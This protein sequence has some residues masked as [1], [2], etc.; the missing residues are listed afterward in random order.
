VYGSRGFMIG[1]FAVTKIWE[2]LRDTSCAIRCV[3]DW[4]GS[5]TI[6]RCGMLFGWV[7]S[8]AEA[9]PTALVHGLN[10]LL[11]DGGFT[12]GLFGFFD[13]AGQGALHAGGVGG[14]DVQ[15]VVVEKEDAAGVAAQ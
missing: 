9:R 2:R 12:E 7:G 13:A 8:R 11:D 6:I 4:S 5:C 10:W 3:L 14:F 15:Q 1:R